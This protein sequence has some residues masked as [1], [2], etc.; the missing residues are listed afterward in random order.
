MHQNENENGC[1]T[2]GIHTS[3]CNDHVTL[4]VCNAICHEDKTPTSPHVVRDMEQE[5]GATF[6]ALDQSLVVS[7]TDACA[8]VNQVLSTI[9]HEM[10]VD[11]AAMGGDINGERNE[12]EPTSLIPSSPQTLN[13]TDGKTV[14]QSAIKAGDSLEKT[15]KGSKKNKKSGSPRGGMSR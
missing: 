12:K 5:E 4:D 13:S 14:N 7:N 1:S 9:S 10:N 6:T 2:S 8:T 15:K 3:D 11:V